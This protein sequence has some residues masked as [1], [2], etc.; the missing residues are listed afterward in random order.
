MHKKIDPP[1]R[2][3]ANEASEKYPRS[4]ILMQMDDYNPSN[5]MGTVL[6]VG[7]DLDE[8]YDLLGALNLENTGI[9]DGLIHQNSLGGIVVGT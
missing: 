2:M 4:Y 7:D 5:D 6:Y 9:V 1:L 3:T 8:L